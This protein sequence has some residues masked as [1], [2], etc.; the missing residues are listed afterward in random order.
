MEAEHVLVVGERRG[1]VGSEELRRDLPDHG[2]QDTRRVS[3]RENKPKAE[4]VAPFDPLDGEPKF[5]ELEPNRANGSDSS[6]VVGMWREL[7]PII[8]SSAN[9]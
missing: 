9:P 4:N 2:A 6:T 7:A 3:G 1:H 8:R 5:R